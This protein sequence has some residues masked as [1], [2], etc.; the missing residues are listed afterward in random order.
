MRWSYGDFASF[1]LVGIVNGIFAFFLVF[2]HRFWRLGC[3]PHAL[4][5]QVDNL[6]GLNSLTEINLR[7][8]VVEYATLPHTFTEHSLLS[9]YRP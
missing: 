6:I 5:V 4:F 3:T 1:V 8:N 9:N 7:R 2:A